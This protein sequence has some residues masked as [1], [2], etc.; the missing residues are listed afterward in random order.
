MIGSNL[1]DYSD[2]CILVSGIITIIG[3]WDNANTKR[4]EE[5]KIK[6]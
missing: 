5:I 3:V 1:C 6:E 4:A 2:V